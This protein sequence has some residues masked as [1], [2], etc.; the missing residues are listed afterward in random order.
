[1]PG[2]KAS[3]ILR[4]EASLT[5]VATTKDEDNAAEGRFSSAC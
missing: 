3:E 4:S 5:Y 1:M 2:C